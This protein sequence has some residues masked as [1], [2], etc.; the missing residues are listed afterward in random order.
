MVKQLEAQGKSVQEACERIARI[1][2]MSPLAARGSVP[3]MEHEAGNSH[4]MEST[5][6]LRAGTAGT[7][8]L[9]LIIRQ[10]DGHAQPSS[11]T[12]T[13][14]T[15]AS[16][17]ELQ[18]RISG[19][20][21]KSVNAGVQH[22]IVASPYSGRVAESSGGG[23][24]GPSKGDHEAGSTASDDVAKGVIE[25]QEKIAALKL[26]GA[27]AAEPSWAKEERPKE[28]RSREERSR[29]GPWHSD[30][31]SNIQ[32]ESCTEQRTEEL[33]EESDGGVR[34]YAQHDDVLAHL[35]DLK[36]LLQGDVLS[37][38]RPPKALSRPVLSPARPPKP[39][40]CT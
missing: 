37:P 16:L 34:Q 13:P 2:S 25:L 21:E 32:R 5:P 33:V 28:V 11:S 6:E 23:Q 15:N 19:I 7:A 9:D 18:H 40:T 36:A 24:H 17:A 14:D 8:S 26:S 12:G 3:P 1:G 10:I 27:R 22:S 39:Y 31:Q 30:G 38:A 4:D 20:R 35:E 29:D